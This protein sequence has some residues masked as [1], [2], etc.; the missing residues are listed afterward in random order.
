ML[1]Y[2]KRLVSI[3]E[4]AE[5]LVVSI[6][7]LRRWETSSRLAVQHAASGHRRYDSAKLKPEL[8]H[9]GDASRRRT[10]A[11]GVRTAVEESQC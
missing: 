8:F 5:S 1:S 10:A 4:A 2:M 6:A 3:G 7:T 11:C 9:S